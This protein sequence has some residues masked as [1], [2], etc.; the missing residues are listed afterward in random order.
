M[1]P[2]SVLNRCEL[3]NLQLTPAGPA[4]GAVLRQAD[5]WKAL[6]S[7][8]HKGHVS[9]K[10]TLPLRLES[11]PWIQKPTCSDS[12]SKEGGQ[13][14]QRRERKTP[15]STRV[16]GSHSVNV[17]EEFNT[18]PAFREKL[19]QPLLRRRAFPNRL[20]AATCRSSQ[21]PVVLFAG[22]V[23]WLI[24]ARSQRGAKTGS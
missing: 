19:V 24:H 20:P 6:P 22:T 3:R 21:K 4:H 7:A 15:V 2:G 8:A 17:M 9:S 16:G 1:F 5:V 12:W 10:N 13:K 18:H 14:K 11:A 23:K